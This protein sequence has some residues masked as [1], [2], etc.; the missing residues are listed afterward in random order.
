MG[1][2]RG[3]QVETYFTVDRLHADGAGLIRGIVPGVLAALLVLGLLLIPAAYW[4]AR[5]VAWYERERQAMIRLTVQASSAERRRMAGELHDGV[6]QD[7]AG[8]GY[9][10]TAL[11]TQIAGLASS[12]SSESAPPIGALRATLHIVQRLVHDDVLALR[13]LTGMQYT[14]D[15]SAADPVAAL[16]VIVDG[17]RK[18]G[19]AVEMV[20]EELPPMPAAH[21]AALIRVGREA[22]R[23]AA[24]HAPG[25]TVTLTLGTEYGVAFVAVTD[26]G[27][28]FDPAS[29]LGPVDGHIGL[30]LLADAA[31]G[32]GGRLDLHSRRGMGTTVRL[33]VPVPPQPHRSAAAGPR[34]PAGPPPLPPRRPLPPW[35]QADRGEQL[36][37]L[38]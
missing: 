13:E 30:A 29:A 34:R 14:A 38:Q 37:L 25:A 27:P 11:D 1:A 32:V 21:R 9:A 2:W 15:G 22:L 35:V 36:A 33:T 26:E 16:R 8:V 7:L 23:N 31:E 4:L 28:G 6:I 5:R 20:V 12:G 19:T 10:L 17:L 18:E 3:P 24:K